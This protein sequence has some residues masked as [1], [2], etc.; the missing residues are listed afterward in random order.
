MKSQAVCGQAIHSQLVSSS[1][2]VFVGGLGSCDLW[3]AS[4]V[5]SITSGRETVEM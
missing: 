1:T 2:W 4:S 5:R 3:K